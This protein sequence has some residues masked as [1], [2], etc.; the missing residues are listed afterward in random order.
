MI[1][2]VDATRS[3]NDISRF[4][5]ARFNAGAVPGYFKKLWPEECFPRSWVRSSKPVFFDF[6]DHAK[7]RGDLWC[8]LP[9]RDNGYAM[10][11]SISK[12]EFLEDAHRLAH[13]F[14]RKR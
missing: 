7:A 6:G 14:P 12:A 5:R 4:E 11:A 8:L 2:V 1:W 9:G 10:V 3:E 13:S